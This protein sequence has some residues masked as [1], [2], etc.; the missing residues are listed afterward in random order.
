M[1][2]TCGQLLKRLQK[3][4]ES[5]AIRQFQSIVKRDPDLELLSRRRVSVEQKAALLTRKIE[6]FQKKKDQL[7]AKE[8]AAK[9]KGEGQG[10]ERE[11]GTGSE[12]RK[13]LKEE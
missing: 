12:P 5:G 11:E 4:V 6:E 9:A 1:I 13:R 2:Y 8:E 7:A 3:V 10:V